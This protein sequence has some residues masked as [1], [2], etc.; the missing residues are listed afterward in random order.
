MDKKHPGGIT[1]VNTNGTALAVATLPSRRRLLAGSIALGAAASAL[2]AAPPSAD[3]SIHQEVDFKAGPQR[4]YE[5]LLDEKQFSAFSGTAA[6]IHREAGG[7]FKLFGGRVIGRN[8]ELMPN[9]RVVQAWRV[10]TWPS[11][12]YSIVRFEL[13]AQGSGTRIV[14]DHIGFAPEDREHLSEG[15]PRMYWNPLRKYLDA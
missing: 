3:A 11:G 5:A 1:T 14:F 10:E 7:A 15:W 6:Q 8:I 9:R 4:I 12:V 13:N 2:T